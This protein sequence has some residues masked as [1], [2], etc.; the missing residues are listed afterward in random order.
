MADGYKTDLTQTDQTPSVRRKTSSK[1]P[2][3]ENKTPPRTPIVTRT[4]DKATIT[5]TQI[6]NSQR[7]TKEVTRDAPSKRHAVSKK[8]E[9]REITQA[10][11]VIG[12]KE[13]IPEQSKRH[14]VAGSGGSGRK[15][16]GVRLVS[17]EAKDGNNVK[18]SAKAPNL[19]TSREKSNA[20][21]YLAQVCHNRT[22]LDGIKLWAAMQRAFNYLSVAALVSDKILCV[23]GGITPHLTSFDVL[24]QHPKPVRNP[25]QGLCSDMVWSDPDTAYDFWRPNSRG[26]GFFFGRRTT[27]DFCERFGIDMIVRGHQV[28]LEGYS[29]L[30]DKRVVTI[31]SAP[32][33]TNDYKNAGCVLKVAANLECELVALVPDYPGSFAGCQERLEISKRLWDPS[34]EVFPESGE[35]PKPIIR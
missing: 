30:W 16:K 6:E 27:E 22:D 32:C 31:F 33:Y 8:R 9:R 11:T 19:L 15:E 23:H 24:R 10:T 18:S 35:P 21:T 13:K 20:H 4:R 1:E 7:R 2:D 34:L 14:G 26:C 25:Y 12:S 28:C 29:T 17:P 3:K 5:T